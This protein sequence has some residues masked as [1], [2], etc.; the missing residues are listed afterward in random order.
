MRATFKFFDE[1]TPADL[2]TAVNAFT[3]TLAPENVMGFQYSGFN[4]G[5][6]SHFVCG[7]WYLA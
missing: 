5:T 6:D 4:D 1:A 3:A 2:T 7:V